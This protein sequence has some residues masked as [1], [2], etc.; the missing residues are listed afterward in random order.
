MVAIPTNC[1]VC[2]IDIT[3]PPGAPAIY[4]LALIMFEY[5]PKYRKYIQRQYG[6]YLPGNY[7]TCM[8]CLLNAMGVPTMDDVIRDGHE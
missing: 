1:S 8:G 2:G 5:D 3:P 6:D 4:G 7:V